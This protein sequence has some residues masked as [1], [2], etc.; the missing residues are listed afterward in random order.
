VRERSRWRY[1]VLQ[2]YL[3]QTCSVLLHYDSSKRCVCPLYKLVYSF[4]VVKLFLKH[5]VLSLLV[6]T[7]SL[8]PARNLYRSASMS[9]AAHLRDKSRGM[10][11]MFRAILIDTYRLLPVSIPVTKVSLCVNDASH[12][13]E[14]RLLVRPVNCFLPLRKG[15]P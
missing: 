12:D 14:L 5:P 7:L 9:L 8:S 3:N 2:Y 15:R 13:A 6:L 1:W 4:K 11:P 10:Y